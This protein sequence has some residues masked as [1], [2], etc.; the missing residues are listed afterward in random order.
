MRQAIRDEY[1]AAVDDY[2]AG[3]ITDEGFEDIEKRFEES[4]KGLFR[5]EYSAGCQAE[6]NANEQLAI[7]KEIKQLKIQNL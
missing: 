1:N 4:E 2:N 7:F 5:K 3:K 6:I